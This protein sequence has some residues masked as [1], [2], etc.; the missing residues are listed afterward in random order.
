MS[1][2]EDN[3]FAIIIYKTQDSLFKNVE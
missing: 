2:S 1:K 3:I